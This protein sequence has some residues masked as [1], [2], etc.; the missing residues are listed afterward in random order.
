MIETDGCQTDQE[1]E[2]EEMRG[3]E[4]KIWSYSNILERC[5][6]GMKKG[7]ERNGVKD[8][9]REIREERYLE[10]EK[11]IYIKRRDKNRC[12]ERE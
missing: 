8:G 10:R 11:K 1:K 3:R 7:R 5:I 6:E 12:T 4:G 2:R 9:E